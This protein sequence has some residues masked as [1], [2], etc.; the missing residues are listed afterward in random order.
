VKVILRDD[1][2]VWRRFTLTS[3]PAPAVLGVVL[4][5]KR[6]LSMSGLVLWLVVLLALALLCLAR[7]AWFGGFYRG[8]MTVGFQVSR[9]LGWFALSLIFWLV[10]TPLGLILRG[11]G[12][13]PLQ[14]RRD[15]Q[16]RS[17]WRAPRERHDLNR[18]F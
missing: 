5:W 18:M 4:W 7:P 6:L 10:V 11:V 12:H 13:D 17:Y 14:L 2:R 3:L 8:G 9:A 1:P 16:R 15:P